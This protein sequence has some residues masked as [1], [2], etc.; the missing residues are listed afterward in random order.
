MRRVFDLLVQDR[1]PDPQFDLERAT[2]RAAPVH[3]REGLV[4]GDVRLQRR[5]A[6]DH[7]PEQRVPREPAAA[8]TA[9]V[10]QAAAR[11]HPPVQHTLT[12][13]T[14][15]HEPN[16]PNQNNNKPQIEISWLPSGQHRPEFFIKGHL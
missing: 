4:Q 12:T 16:Q 15:P 3:Q 7:G 13:N 6:D 1:S 2:G 10:R 5:E 11:R 14:R 9:R 8:T